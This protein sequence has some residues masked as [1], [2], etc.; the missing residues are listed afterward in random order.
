MSKIVILKI[1]KYVHF[2]QICKKTLKIK[3]LLL[4]FLIMQLLIV[5]II[6]YRLILT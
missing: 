6:N 4:I 3:I 5:S 1:V 2:S